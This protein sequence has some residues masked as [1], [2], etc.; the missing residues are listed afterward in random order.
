MESR[1]SC[2]RVAEKS[3][4]VYRNL[5]LLQ[6]RP[7]ECV[8][9]SQLIWT[10]LFIS[11]QKYVLAVIRQAAEKLLE[12]SLLVFPPVEAPEAA[13]AS[14][15]SRH[16]SAAAWGAPRA[17]LSPLGRLA[18]PGSPVRGPQADEPLPL[19]ARSPLDVVVLP[20]VEL[21]PKGLPGGRVLIKFYQLETFSSE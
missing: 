11:L 19:G 1:R 9:F 10:L 18:A 7:K 16:P 8:A 3:D 13:R 20:S 2:V 17:Y 12:K 4:S 5:R 6:P 21:F 14:S 15:F